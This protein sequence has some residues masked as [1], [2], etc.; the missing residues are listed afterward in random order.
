M[1]RKKKNKFFDVSLV[2]LKTE[3]SRQ[4][5]KAIVKLMRL[6][7]LC[8]SSV[9]IIL[10]WICKNSLINTHIL[11]TVMT[12]IWVICPSERNKLTQEWHIEVSSV[13]AIKLSY[14]QIQT[15]LYFQNLKNSYTY[16]SLRKSE[17]FIIPYKL[18][19]IITYTKCISGS[20]FLHVHIAISKYLQEKEHNSALNAS[21]L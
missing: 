2:A 14:I 6:F 17:S 7:F 12:F 1:K 18:K 11:M 5:D 4:R 21:Y 20:V 10:S 3:L 15:I 13:Y 16:T 19:Y 8:S 9:S